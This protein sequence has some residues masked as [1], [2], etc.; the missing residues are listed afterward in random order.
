MWCD[1]Q[2]ISQL[3]SQRS[4]QELVSM[5]YEVELR[6]HRDTHRLL[7]ATEKQ[8]TQLKEEGERRSS[9][10]QNPALRRVE[11]PKLTIDSSDTSSNRLCAALG[12]GISLVECFP[13]INH[14][15][16][17]FGKGTPSL[18]VKKTNCTGILVQLIVMVHCISNSSY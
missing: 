12:E 13:F 15:C 18:V 14:G 3:Q 1:G 5:L 2:V 11:T 8:L 6:K 4:R 17:A 7:A 16:A 10:M 9:A